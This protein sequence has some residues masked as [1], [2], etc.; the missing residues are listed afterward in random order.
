LLID[1]NWRKSTKSGTGMDCVEV[2]LNGDEIEVRNSKRAE[3][4]SVLFT[5]DEWRAFID[6]AKADE[7]QV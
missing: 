6:G 7:F 1:R 4:G 5:K 3:A 2:R